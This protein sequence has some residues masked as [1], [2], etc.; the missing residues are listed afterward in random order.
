M[1]KLSGSFLVILGLLFLST[2]AS[3]SFP[4]QKRAAGTRDGAIRVEVFKSLEKGKKEFLANIPVTLWASQ[5]S[6]MGGVTPATNVASG[7][8]DK[9]GHFKFTRLD[10]GSN[11]IYTAGAK[12]DGQEFKSDLM[13]FRDT[14]II[15]VELEIFPTSDS[16]KEISV[17]KNHLI[18]ERGAEGKLNFTEYRILKN[19]SKTAYFPKENGGLE[20]NIPAKVTGL[21]VDQVF[22]PESVTYKEGEDHFK[23]A[24]PVYPGDSRMVNIGLTYSADFSR[25]KFNFEQKNRYPLL[26]MVILVSDP[27]IVISGRNVTD[28]GSKAFGEKVFNQYRIGGLSS[29]EDL[30]FKIFTKGNEIEKG[31]FLILV[32]IVLIIIFAVVASFKWR[33]KE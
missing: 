7:M 26:S 13:G 31:R 12:V 19:G 17:F 24:M 1:N 11:Y 30:S 8:T 3:Y 32:V 20:L 25:S 10:T 6:M 4:S 28:L 5:M 33:K 29:G 22:S 21:T 15:E 2:Q 18:I 27:E 14:K 16:D 9:G 23:L